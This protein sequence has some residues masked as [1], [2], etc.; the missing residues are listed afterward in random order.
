MKVSKKIAIILLGRPGS[1]KDTQA[2]LLAKKFGLIHIISSKI[3]E[4][5]LETREKTV[6]LDGKV[7]NLNRERLAQRSGR[8]NNF[9]FV[10]SLIKK[11]IK[12][13]GRSLS[14]ETGK[15]AGQADA[16]VLA[17]YGDTVI[18]A[19]VVAVPAKEEYRYTGCL[20]I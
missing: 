16:A 8:L 15:L 11:E 3:I 12:W 20:Y 19:T 18:L 2:E 5:V 9:N 4:K 10:S 7:Y 6:N 14:L 17:R 13:G 1:G